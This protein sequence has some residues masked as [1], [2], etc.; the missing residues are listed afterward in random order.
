MKTLTTQA[1]R[2]N[3]AI[4]QSVL[5]TVAVSIQETLAAFSAAASVTLLVSLSIW[6]ASME[7]S[8]LSAAVSWGLGF[9]FAGL[10][11]DGRGSTAVLQVIT[12]LSL[13]LLAF[14]QNY[15]SADFVI[16]AG[17]LLATW[18]AGFVFRQLR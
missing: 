17:A 9:I 18:S 10:A 5:P 12:A 15:V 16:A 11:V 3:Q 14:L 13:F 4:S 1:T 6:I 7:V 8:H 2:Q